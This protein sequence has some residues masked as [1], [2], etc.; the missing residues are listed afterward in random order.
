MEPSERPSHP[1]SR[2]LLSASRDRPDLAEVPQNDLR[3]T[4]QKARGPQE[5]PDAEKLATTQTR[6]WGSW[7][8]TACRR[9]GDG[10]RG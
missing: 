3:Q 6:G 8:G 4:P 10:P 7:E 9:A 1:P 2:E 5:L